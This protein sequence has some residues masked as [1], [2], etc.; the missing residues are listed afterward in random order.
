MER[1]TSL[2]ILLLQL[3]LLPLLF[4]RGCAAAAGDKETAWLSFSTEELELVAKDHEN[5]TVF[6]L[7]RGTTQECFTV[8]FT[9]KPASPSIVPLSDLL[10]C[11]DQLPTPP[12][13]SSPRPSKGCR[14]C[15]TD[16]A[17]ETRENGGDLSLL[18]SSAPHSHPSSF[19]QLLQAWAYRLG[20]GQESSESGEVIANVTLDIVSRWVGKTTL[21]VATNSSSVGVVDTFVEVSVIHTRALD[22]A[23]AVMG[24]AYTVIWDV[25]FLPQVILNWRRKNVEGYSFDN[26]ALN[27]IAYLY[28]ALFNVA[29]YW[30]PLIKDQFKE[31]YPRTVNHVE[32][33]D[34]FF[35]TYAF[36][37]Q[38]VLAVQCFLYGRNTGLSVSWPCIGLVAASVLAVA[39]DCVLVAFGVVWWLDVFYLMSY[40]KLIITPLKYI[41]QVYVI[42]KVKSTKGF[43]ILGAVMDFSGGVLS[44]AQM[45]LLSA[46]SNDYLSIF[47]NFSKFGLGVVTL[48]FDITYF[49]QHFYY[50]LRVRK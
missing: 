46:N 30:V 1:H 42:Y 44:L 23:S 5:A 37:I 26:V 38:I 29:F 20:G 16:H 36:F 15:E 8:N 12:T 22:V 35:A 41:P 45:F 21:S 25:S 49:F 18:P 24:W 13:P 4:S 34:V 3:L 28:Y 17:E 27:V 39:V 33:N 10:L 40:M 50:H 2:D 14:G 9:Y 31:R 11:P 7:L 6:L 48:I 19:M 47:T 32:T 43:S